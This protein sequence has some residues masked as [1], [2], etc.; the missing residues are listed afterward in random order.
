MGLS[1]FTR[2]ESLKDKC[3]KK[4]FPNSREVA[5]SKCPANTS[6]ERRWHP[7]SLTGWHTPPHAVH[8]RLL[9]SK[10]NFK[11]APLKIFPWNKIQNI[12]YFQTSISS[13]FSLSCWARP[14][15][16]LT[17][18]ELRNALVRHHRNINHAVLKLKTLLEKGTDVRDP[19]RA[20]DTRRLRRR[21]RN[22]G[23]LS[24]LR[25][26]TGN[27]TSPWT[28]STYAPV[29]EPRAHTQA[30]GR[31]PVT[32]PWKPRNATSDDAPCPGDPGVKY[33]SAR[34][35]APRG[36]PRRHKCTFLALTEVSPTTLSPSM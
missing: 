11:F 21:L 15:P 28:P 31:G 23:R 30:A 33:V 1:S 14:G 4:N 36:F 2:I 29:P 12:N 5:Q 3:T 10:R 18:E 22:Q 32:S 25:L 13:C 17:C 24:R 16:W 35:R 27:A 34:P 20:N 19:S 8:W 7:P 26:S 6:T 9:P